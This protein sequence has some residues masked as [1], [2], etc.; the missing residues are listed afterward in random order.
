MNTIKFSRCPTDPHKGEEWEKLVTVKNGEEL[1]LI[2]VNVMLAA[3]I[4]IGWW[5]EDTFADI[6]MWFVEHLLGDIY[7]KG[8]PVDM[9]ETY[10]I[11]LVFRR[12]NGEIL[13]TARGYK[14]GTW[15]FYKA[16]RGNRF[17]VVKTYL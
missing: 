10:V 7:N 11:L 14:V 4:E 13:H 3:D 17:K 16:N 9:S 8:Q 15:H 1:R 5:R 6:D 2:G 12:E